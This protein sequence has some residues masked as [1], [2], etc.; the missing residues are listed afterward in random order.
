MRRS[1]LCLCVLV[2]WIAAPVRAQADVAGT[3]VDAES[4]AP[5]GWATLRLVPRATG[6]PLVI[7]ADR[8][9]AF[10]F[11]GVPEGPAVL[12]ASYVAYRPSSDTLAVGAE[13]LEAVVVRLAALTDIGNVDVEADRAGLTGESAG[14]QRVRPAD[15]A[16]VP[17]AG[18]A[19]DLAAYL[20]TLP[21]VASVGDRGGQ[22]FIRGSTPEQSGA[23]LDG[24]RVERPFHILG[25]YSV[26]PAE[27]IGRADVYAGGYPARY[28]GRIGSVLDVT[29]RTGEVETVEASASVASLQS[30]VQVSGPVVPGRVTALVSVRESLVEAAVPQFL[31]QRFPYRFGDRL[32]SVHARLGGT[33]EVQLTGLH[34]TDRGDVAGSRFGLYGEPVP[35][36]VDERDDY[37]IRW[38]N[39]GAG[40]TVRA[41]P[42]DWGVLAQAAYSESRNRLGPESAVRRDASSRGADLRAE[43]TRRLGRVGARLGAFRYD[44]EV[45]VALDDL[46]L[47]T[48]R[49]TSDVAETGGYA[50]LDAELAPG[51][52]VEG[53]LRVAR[54]EPAGAT[55]WEPRGRVVWTPSGALGRF[56][57]SVTAAVGV[58]R[59]GVVG[60][61]DARESGDVFVAYVPVPE[62]ADLPSAVHALVGWS[63]TLGY[64]VRVSTEAYVKRFPQVFVPTVTPVLSPSTSFEDAEGRAWGG[65]VRLDGGVFLGG[66]A[67]VNVS[68]GYGYQTVEYTTALETIPAAHDRRHQGT[69]LARLQAGEFGVTAQWQY[70]SG[71]PYTPSAGFDR[72]VDYDDPDASVR[73]PGEVRA[74]YGAR[75]ARRLPAYHR[76]D[77]WAERRAA[78]DAYALTVR[79]GLVN[80]YNRANLFYFDLAEF[81]RVEQVPFLPTFGLTLSTR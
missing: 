22:L 20:T 16:L 7:A 55:S 46:G 78:L 68:A 30:G 72:W 76:L 51:L 29:T 2:G 77:L 13:P 24:I 33:V 37:L 15:L 36:P 57:R 69:V 14:L 79:L 52:V 70:G 62:G 12:Q 56:T 75:N 26:F 38:E 59:Q 67:T 66:D 3:V 41:R 5:L 27:V 64:G 25:S 61:R 8:D 17:I 18:G 1:L 28:G 63:G 31:G 49:D 42:G 73:T 71:L 45:R 19:G 10:R 32:A 54:F 43:V 9:G 6:Q 60:F 40:L 35:V 80:V 34:S 23:T 48:P 44:G 50:E 58:Y 4:G 21:G 11:E 39:G 81:R 47:A 74:L 65:D 53:G